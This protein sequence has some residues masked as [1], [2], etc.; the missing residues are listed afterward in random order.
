MHVI[1][2]WQQWATGFAVVEGD[3]SLSP[4]RFLASQKI[5]L[6]ALRCAR[7]QRDCATTWQQPVCPILSK[8]TLATCCCDSKKIFISA[9]AFH[10]GSMER[11]LSGWWWHHIKHS[12]NTPLLKHWPHGTVAISLQAHNCTSLNSNVNLWLHFPTMSFVYVVA[13][14]RD[15]TEPACTAPLLCNESKCNECSPK[16]KVTCYNIHTKCWKIVCRC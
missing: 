12:T 5:L 9:T 8:F 1:F 13:S 16:M 15:A 7:R 14:H 4:R 11:I 6:V 2:G 10:A 3:S